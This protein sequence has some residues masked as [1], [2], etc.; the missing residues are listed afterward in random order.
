MIPMTNTDIA[1]S[2]LRDLEAHAENEKFWR[3]HDT[4]FTPAQRRKTDD[5]APKPEAANVR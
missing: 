5:R 3:S 1:R 4:G 2:I